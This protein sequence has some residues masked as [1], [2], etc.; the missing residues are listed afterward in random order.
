MGDDV[1]TT[2]ATAPTADYVFGVSRRQ[3]DAW[4]RGTSRYTLLI[5]SPTD[6]ERQTPGMRGAYGVDP[7]NKLNR[8]DAGELEALVWRCLSAHPGEPMTFNELSVRLFD[9]TADVTGDTAF[10]RA[11]W[12]MI[13]HGCL[14]M[15][16]EAPVLLIRSINL[17]ELSCPAPVFTPPKKAVQASLF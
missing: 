8:M 17:Y 16:M 7:H 4:R 12:S 11:V 10:E 13:E 9:L 3:I 1:H 5:R 6:P 2:T 14:A 15:T